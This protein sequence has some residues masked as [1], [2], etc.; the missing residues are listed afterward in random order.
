M[1]PLVAAVSAG[2]VVR[3]IVDETYAP[4][5]PGKACL[6]C[7]SAWPADECETVHSH[8]RGC[9]SAPAPAKCANCASLEDDARRGD[10]YDP[11]L[12]HGGRR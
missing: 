10:R 4:G 8:A 5:V 9:S 1:S 3:G 12:A 7:D 2:V 11:S 6:E